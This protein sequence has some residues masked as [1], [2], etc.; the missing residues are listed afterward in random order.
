M[1]AQ[2]R[3]VAIAL[4]LIFSLCQAENVGA[5]SDAK[6]GAATFREYWCFTCHGAK[7]EGGFGPDLAG[8]Q[9]SFDQFKHAI[10][11]PWG[12]MPAFTEQQLGDRD[13]GNIHTY[14]SSLPRVASPGPWRTVLPPGAPIGLTLLA[15]TVGCAQ[16]HGAAVGDIRA[17][18]GAVDGDFEWFK[19]MTYEHATAMP[20]HRQRVGAAAG[21]VRMGAYSRMRVPEST[22]QEI[23]RYIAN[24]LKLRARVQAQ[25]RPAT[26][27]D[28]YSLVVR[29]TGAAGRGLTAEDVT[30]SL[31][32]QPG[33]TVS[34]VTGAGYQGVRRDEQE[35]ADVVVLATAA[36]GSDAGRDL[37]PHAYERWRHH[38]RPGPL[39]QAG[40]GNWRP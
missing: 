33:T 4:F 39:G 36:A 25:L 24:D 3:Q 9:L 13:I 21:P 27:S 29:N 1:K 14:F 18:A 11:Q 15:G 16:C 6:A 34:R 5:Q 22:L 2:M 20:A 38:P 26:P 31:I 40:A 32:L 35:Q 23:W 8:R 19:G 7:G 10:R 30:I 28:S 17:A 37:Y 12:V